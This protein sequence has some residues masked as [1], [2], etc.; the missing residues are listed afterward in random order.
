MRK[1]PQEIL[2]LTFNDEWNTG[3][4]QSIRSF[5][6]NLLIK[7]VIEGEC[8]SSSH[9]WGNSDWLAPLQICLIKNGIVGGA[10]TEY[11]DTDLIDLNYC[12]EE[13]FQEI[14]KELIRAL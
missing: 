8:F 2:D 12:D 9:P 1:T 3:Y 6:K 7:V 13:E 10:I 11:K 14:M 5:L 4:I